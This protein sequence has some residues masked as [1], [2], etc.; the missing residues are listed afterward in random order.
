M[1]A[2]DRM[3][4]R[5]APSWAVTSTLRARA[6]RFIEIELNAAFRPAPRSRII[7]Q[8]PEPPAVLNS[9]RAVILVTLGLGS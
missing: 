7:E 6:I 4:N 5:G 8:V 1:G 9:G 2:P 3:S